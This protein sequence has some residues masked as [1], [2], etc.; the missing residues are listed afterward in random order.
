MIRDT[1]R[2][3][4]T[5]AVVAGAMMLAATPM[6]G[7]GQNWPQFRGIHRDGASTETGLL[8]GWPD[9]GPKEIW[10]VAPAEGYSGISV[11][12]DRVYM[13]YAAD[14]DG[15]PT[16]FAAAFDAASGKE[17]FLRGER[18]LYAIKEKPAD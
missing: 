4:T 14:H 13:M 16:E 8:S 3:L 6:A 15:E 7:E 9:G 2:A 11:V 10:R 1:R 18:L 17:L 12:G 5:L